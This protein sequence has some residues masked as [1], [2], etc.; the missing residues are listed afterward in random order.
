MLLVFFRIYLRVFCQLSSELG[1][2][3]LF[4]R[5][6]CVHACVLTCVRAGVHVCGEFKKCSQ[7]NLTVETG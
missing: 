5:G 4:G 7:P 1:E 6:E 3:V 2:I